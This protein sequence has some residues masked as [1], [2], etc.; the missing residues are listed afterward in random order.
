MRLGTASSA[1]FRTQLPGLTGSIVFGVVLA[2]LTVGL[3]S[4]VILSRPTAWE[5][6]TTLLVLPRNTEGA[7]QSGLFELLNQGQIVTTYAALLR[8]AVF[9]Q[10]ATRAAGVKARPVALDAAPL[11][12]TFL[13]RLTANAPTAVD[14]ARLA[15]AAAER[16][17]PYVA[18]LG[19]PFAVRALDA[20]A[21]VATERTVATPGLAATLLMIGVIVGLAGQQAFLQMRR[22]RGSDRGGRRQDPPRPDVTRPREER[23]SRG[24]S[25]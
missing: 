13:I 15:Q 22:L 5:S 12:D 9:T 23:H 1:S 21:V 11:P 24:W 2:S 14:A 8:S 4:S 3:G 25:A 17:P 10:E 6:Q 18:N 19:H 16:A 20:R 7:S